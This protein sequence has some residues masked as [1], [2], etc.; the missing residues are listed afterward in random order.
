[1]GS[2]NCTY[3]LG[4]AFRYALHSFTVVGCLHELVAPPSA[5]TG[6]VHSD[7]RCFLALGLLGATENPSDPPYR[8]GVEVQEDFSGVSSCGACRSTRPEELLSQRFEA[9]AEA[10]G[11]DEC[12]EWCSLRLFDYV[13]EVLLNLSVECLR[14][15]PAV[16]RLFDQ[17]C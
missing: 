8:V 11:I 9:Q 17:R 13:V 1:M 5:A 12:E 10:E 4:V 2:H 14:S 6:G 7:Q 16:T 3:A 15:E